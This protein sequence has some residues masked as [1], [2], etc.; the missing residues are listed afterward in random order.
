M[1]TADPD[2]QRAVQG[3][4][5]L[6]AEIHYWLPDH[7]SLLQQFVWQT[8]DLAPAFPELAKFLD[9]WRRSIE[10]PL[11]SVRIAHNALIRPSEWRAVDGVLTIH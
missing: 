2:F 11:H 3:Y 5:L 6:T 4:G 7:P 1:K 9:H 10:A 8:Y